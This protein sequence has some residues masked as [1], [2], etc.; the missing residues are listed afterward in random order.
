MNND[1][2][3]PKL[4]LNPDIKNNHEI[5]SLSKD[6]YK[7]VKLTDE[8]MKTVEDFAEKIELRDSNM[9]V[10]YGAEAQKK[11]T[12][13]SENALSLVRTKDLGTVGN[14][15]TDVVLE[16]KGFDTTEKTKGVLGFFKKPVN[17]VE[18]LK[19]KYDKA[20]ANIDKVCEIL[21]NHQLELLK[22]IAMLD[23]MFE[24][25]K[26]YFKE[27]TMYI[28]AGK[29]KLEQ[30]RM[31][32]LKELENIARQSSR[33]EDVQAASDLANL[34]ERFDKKLHDLELTRTV[35]LQMGPQIRIVQG[36]NILMSEKIQSTIAN[37]IPL[38]KSQ[39]VI[40]IGVAHSAEAAKAQQAVSNT[41]NELLKRNAEKLKSVA[42]QTAQESERAII[43][44]ET[45]KYTNDQ[46]IS[47][48]DDVLKIQKDGREKR[49]QAEKEL[50]KI[51]NELKDRLLK[52]ER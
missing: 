17:K 19:I 9:I 32:E 1:L 11:M 5:E 28:L 26:V 39:M 45:L 40:S 31:G 38:W 25:N 20:E 43:D 30:V 33:P 4:T 42:L 49:Q 6:E 34:C 50:V 2:P 13:F 18:S 46:L 41:T 51:E 3:T 10:R 37:T 52:I 27:L 47:T 29:K 14:I 22:D 16:L 44:I 24:L 12:D 23:K 48:L 8:E 21:E 35:S 7:E 36:N 15:L